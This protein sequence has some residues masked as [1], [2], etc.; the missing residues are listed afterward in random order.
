MF[1]KIIFSTFILLFCCVC[2]P[3]YLHADQSY[4]VEFTGV[5]DTDTLSLLI[6]ASQLV[7]LKDSPPTTKA[8]LKRRVELD[9]PNLIKA[10]HS[11][12][13]FNAQIDFTIND[14]KTPITITYMI[15]TGPVYPFAEFLVVPALEASVYNPAF[16]FTSLR[17]EQL[18]ITLGTPALPKAILNA[19]EALLDK[20]SCAGFACAKTPGREVIADQQS[21]SIKVILYVDS[22]PLC[23]FGEPNISGHKLVK[24]HY[25]SKKL[26]WKPGDVYDPSKIERTQ[27]AL[28]ASGLFSSISIDRDEVKEFSTVPI[29]IE[30]VESKHRS[31]GFGLGYAT[32]RGPGVAAEW[33]HRN[34]RRMGEKV[35]LKTNFWAQTQDA[36]LLYLKTDFLRPRQDLLWLLEYEYEK[37][38]GYTQRFYSLSGII[39]RQLN[40][41]TRVSFGGMFKQLKDTRSDNN[42]DFHLIKS[43]FHL[44]WSNANNILDPTEGT[45]INLR[46][47]PSVQIFK[48]QF[49][50]CINTLIGTCYYPLDQENKI[51]LANKMTFGTIVGATRH[52]IPPSERFYAGSENALRGYHY[53]TVSPLNKKHKPIGGRSMLIYCLEMRLRQ[54]ESI[55][56]VGFYEIGNVYKDYLPSWKEKVLQSVGLGFR[57]HTPVGPLRLDLAFPLNR[58][59]HVDGFF[60]FYLSIGQAF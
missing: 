35:S 20:L 44:R 57:Y 37:T 25:F 48:P 3:S 10:L 59:K 43:P 31:V 14:S 54:S 50:Y 39:E 45:S 32:Q 58:R 49:V 46:V 6:R 8:S 53:L 60:Q 30:V 47:T 24:E 55:G 42:R 33:E 27:L 17:P 15:T 18:G 2:I 16:D 56:W 28:E 9:I 29:A 23:F 4:V 13:Y 21:K 11:Q 38:R 36:T 1:Y 52:S 41:H 34:V 5:T 12:A 51:V 40:D 19:E 22:G 7:A 26:A